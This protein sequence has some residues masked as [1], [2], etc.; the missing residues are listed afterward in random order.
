M[1]AVSFAQ[2]QFRTMGR[3]LKS[4]AEFDADT[5]DRFAKRAAGG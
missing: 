1:F 4:T 2:Y 5:I 3:V